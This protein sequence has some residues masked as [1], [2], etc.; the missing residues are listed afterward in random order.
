MFVGKH[1]GTKYIER[2]TRSY[3]NLDTCIVT[4]NFC[5]FSRFQL[6]KN[7]KYILRFTLIFLVLFF[8]GFF[9]CQI[10]LDLLAYMC[11]FVDNKAYHLRFL[12][13]L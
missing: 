6:F 1:I 4:V 11:L 5:L 8:W 10:V 7:Y 12:L 13:Y 9:S 3:M 2:Q